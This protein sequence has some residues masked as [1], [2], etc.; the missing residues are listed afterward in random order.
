MPKP[1]PKPRPKPMPKPRPMTCQPAQL[2]ARRNVLR[3]H[4]S[5]LVSLASG[6]RFSVENRWFPT[7]NADSR[8]R[9]GDQGKGG[10]IEP[11][12]GLESESVSSTRPVA[13][14]THTNQTHSCCAVSADQFD[15][16]QFD[17]ETALFIRRR[18]GKKR[19]IIV[20]GEG[21]TRA[22]P[23]LLFADRPLS[24]EN[25]NTETLRKGLGAI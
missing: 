18:A 15:C 17:R 6:L 19:G 8:A 10:G 5:D 7:A 1:R 11:R 21:W 14:R 12:M 3:H 9:R 4:A 13:Q 24:A 16:R 25:A 2:C 23:A 20:G 22:L